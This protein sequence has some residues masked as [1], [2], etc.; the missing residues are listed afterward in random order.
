MNFEIGEK[1]AYTSAFLRNTGQLTCPVGEKHLAD[2]RGVITATQDIGFNRALISIQWD[3]ETETKVM[4]GN[5]CKV[6][7]GVPLDHT[8]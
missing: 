1:V 7:N 3:D 5:I 6:K 8:I 4:S 2:Y